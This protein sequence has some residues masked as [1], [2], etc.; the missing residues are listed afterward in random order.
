MISMTKNSRQVDLHKAKNFGQKRCRC[1]KK[2]I[3][4]RR[5]NSIVCPDF[6]SKADVD[7]AKLPISIQNEMKNVGMSLC[8]ANNLMSE[9]KRIK[10]V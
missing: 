2:N 5:A 7:H 4:T 3:I 8:I 6:K 1:R 10:R 9:R